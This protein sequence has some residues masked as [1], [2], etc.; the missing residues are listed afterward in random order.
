MVTTSSTNQSSAFIQSVSELAICFM[1]RV[2]ASFYGQFHHAVYRV[3]PRDVSWAITMSPFTVEWVDMFNLL[4]RQNRLVYSFV[5]KTAHTVKN[6]ASAVKIPV[7]CDLNACL[8][9]MPTYFGFGYWLMAGEQLWP[10]RRHFHTRRIGAKFT[11]RLAVSYLLRPLRQ[12]F[13]DE[14]LAALEKAW[15]MKT[16]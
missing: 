15:N 7:V 14:A 11:L 8:N 1:L 6:S 12:F 4:S 5:K 10:K 9:L 13:C 3:F 2:D 16:S